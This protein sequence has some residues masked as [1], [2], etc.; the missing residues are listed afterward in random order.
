MRHKFRCGRLVLNRNGLV[1]K[2]NLSHGGGIR[3]CKFSHIDI[4]FD[5]I[6]DKLRDIF[7]PNSPN[8]VSMLYDFQR[9]KLDTKRYQ[10]FYDYINQHGLKFN[11]TLLYLCLPAG[12]ERIANSTS[13]EQRRRT[14][15]TTQSIQNQPQVQK[16]IPCI[17]NMIIKIDEDDDDSSHNHLSTQ[18]FPPVNPIAENLRMFSSTSFSNYSFEKSLNEFVDY[19]RHLVTQYKHENIFLQLFEHICDIRGRSSNNLDRLKQESQVIDDK[20]KEVYD[21][22]FNKIEQTSR[23]IKALIELNKI[24]ISHIDPHAII[25]NAFNVFH[26]NFNTLRDQWINNKNNNRQS[27]SVP[28]RSPVIDRTSSK[29]Y[30]T[31]RVSSS[32]SSNRSFHPT[33]S[34]NYSAGRVSSSS[35]RSFGQPPPTNYSAGRVP[36]SS[37]RSSE[38]PPPTNYSAGRVPSS[39]N[40]SFDQPPPT[41]YSAGP[42]PSSSNRPFD[43]PPPTNYAAGRVPSLL[44][45]S[46]DQPP[47]TN[48][49]AGRVASS[50]NRS[51]EQPPPTN[52]SA[53]RVPSSSNRSFDRSPPITRST[54][55]GASTSHSTYQAQLINRPA[56][57]TSSTN[58]SFSSSRSHSET[59]SRKQARTLSSSPHRSSSSSS[60]QKSTEENK[61]N[62]ISLFRN[63]FKSLD[64]LL[65]VLSHLRFTSFYHYV[66]LIIDEIETCRSTIKLSNYESLCDVEKSIESIECRI[67]NRM[68]NEYNHA[69][70]H[71]I[72]RQLEHSY[73]ETLDSIRQ[74]LT[75]F[76]VYKSRI[77]NN[78]RAKTTRWSSS[79]LPLCVEYQ[80][81]ETKPTI[82]INQLDIKI[83]D[84]QSSEASHSSLG[85]EV[86]MEVAKTA[87]EHRPH[88]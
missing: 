1:K 49:S 82:Q 77:E 57:R 87:Y 11:S 9:K 32:S 76:R 60:Y 25:I 79:A 28:L 46:F 45:L 40:R 47:P 20:Q 7:I 54:S 38:Q 86:L 80:H 72:D 27:T 22:I 29:N 33:P 16:K 35:N 61:D 31:G 73:R 84:D 26:Q 15:T 81:I 56:D 6:H 19:L 42:I 59:Y 2:I 71:T 53:G 37:N 85:D 66:K 4:G 48:Y 75:S 5:E 10:N 14:T 62:N 83:D 34:T 17:E 55:R 8:R 51:Y 39:S 3:D 30:S 88:C 70:P 43:Q 52:Y 64:Y 36:S 21:D 69:S 12:N 18:P 63:I 13:T 65:N 23:S 58:F 24:K 67:T 41:N 44:S 68:N 74:L 50:S 78:K